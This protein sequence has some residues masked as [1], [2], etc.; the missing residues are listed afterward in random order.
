MIVTVT[1][2]C[3]NDINFF[4]YLFLDKL[5][6]EEKKLGEISVVNILVKSKRGKIKWKK[7]AKLLG[8][9]EFKLLF[10]NQ[11]PIMTKLGIKRFS[12]INLQKR[13]CK[14]AVLEV[15][16]K[17]KLNPNKLRISLIDETGEHYE[18]L[19]KIIKFSSQIDVITLN[20]RLYLEKQMDLMDEFGASVMVTK[21]KDWLFKSDIVVAPEPI[22][23]PL[24][25]KKESV[26]FSSEINKYLNCLNAY[27]E[28]K[29]E[30]PLKYKK[31][32]PQNVSVEYFLSAL[33]DEYNLSD[34]PMLRPK[35]CL[36]K[37][38][39]ESIEDVAKKIKI[40]CASL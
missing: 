14:N 37:C 17:A 30:I 26:V 4:K 23:E 27:Y 25:I 2:E 7:I 21:N 19:R 36:S 20:E 34:L 22:N 6:V 10:P 39:L 31:L 13:L 1:A 16:N 33:F 9:K 11:L 5:I 12:S 38:G 32:K 29:V 8:K 15:L 35:K 3:I 40:N 18:L 24:P 28:Y